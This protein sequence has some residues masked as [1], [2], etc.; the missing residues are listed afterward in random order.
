MSSFPILDLVIGMIFI[1][2]LLSIICSSM[3][4]IVQTIVKARSRI[5]YR[6]L[7]RIFDQPIVINGG[8]PVRLGIAIMD[9]CSAMVLSTQKK[10][11]SYI[12][13]KNFTT[14]LIDLLTLNPAA[15]ATVPADLPAIATAIQNSTSLSVEM[16]RTLLGFARD[17]TQTF[18]LKPQAGISDI[19]IFRQKVE[20]W[21]DTNMDRLAG[22]LKRRW[23]SWLTF[24]FACVITISSNMDSIAIA[25]FLYSNPEARMQAAKLGVELTKDSTYI[26]QYALTNRLQDA[27]DT[28]DIQ[29]VTDFQN[30]LNASIQRIRMSQTTLNT[31]IPVGWPGKFGEGLTG[32]QVFGLIL[33]ILA[34]MLGAPFWFDILNKV[35]NLRGT[36]PK[37]ASTTGGD[38]NKPGGTKA[39]K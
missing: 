36:G 38:F 11:P 32:L 37:P 26:Q 17:A 20:H 7:F 9:H 39:G 19:S 28:T 1:Y 10:S 27:A 35:A 2:F 34:I 29:S 18:A 21:Y 12:D 14:A 3:V 33:T 6:W 31:L 8:T 16:Q 15:P 5:L 24:V 4:E 13:R 23:S 25:R 22:T 30:R